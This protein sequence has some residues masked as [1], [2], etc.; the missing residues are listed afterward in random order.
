MDP[1]M[2]APSAPWLLFSAPSAPF[3]SKKWTNGADGAELG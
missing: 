3:G 1:S 2:S